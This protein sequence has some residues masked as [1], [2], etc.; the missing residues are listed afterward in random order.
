VLHTLKKT[1]PKEGG[2]EGRA[3]AAG[4]CTQRTAS[5]P[6][7]DHGLRTVNSRTILIKDDDS[8]WKVARQIHT[9]MATVLK[10]KACL[11]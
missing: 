11:R 7:K 1:A 9:S 5:G 6:K 2:Q 8:K 10:I 3:E 4:T